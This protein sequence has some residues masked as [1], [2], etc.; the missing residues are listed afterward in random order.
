MDDPVKI[1]G[2]S[3]KGRNE[4]LNPVNNET[5]DRTLRTAKEAQ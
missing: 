5:N 2:Q 3:L 1:N 4:T